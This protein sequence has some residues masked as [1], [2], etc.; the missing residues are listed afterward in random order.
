MN[1]NFTV[2]AQKFDPSNYTMYSQAIEFLMDDHDDCNCNNLFVE[3]D[4][5]SVSYSCL[6]SFSDESEI[7]G[8]SDSEE[9]EIK[10]IFKTSIYSPTS[11]V[12]TNLSQE[13]THICSFSTKTRN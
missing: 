7:T 2:R 4:L 6:T 11:T 9:H 12:I 1:A 5:F 8:A 10:E 13:E 3:K